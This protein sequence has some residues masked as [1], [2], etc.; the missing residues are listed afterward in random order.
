MANKINISK[1]LLFSLYEKEKLTTY[2]IAKKF[3]CCQ[4]TIWKRLIEFNIKRRTPYELNSNVPSK[5]QLI[6][7]YLNK[8]LS[9]WKIEEKYGFRR[10]T[11]HRKLKEYGLGTRDLA[12]SHIIYPRKDFSG[13]LIEKA[14]LTGFRIGDLGVRKIYPNSKTI[15]VASGSTIKEQIELIENLFKKYGKVNIKATKN[16][17][18][19]IWIALNESFNFLLSKE[20]PNWI[21]KNKKTF[22]AFLA[23]F[24]DAEG[25]ISK[26]NRI[27]YYY[28]LG[29]Y[30]SELLFKIYRNLNRFGIECKEPKS[31]NRKGKMNSQ[32]YKYNSNY[33][34]LRIYNQTI[35]LNLLKELKPYVKHKNK[36]KDLNRAIIGIVN[37]NKPRI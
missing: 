33:W 8:R 9:T 6:E 11:I 10:G 32:G 7:Y 31:D 37:R 21:E 27:T 16:H 2:Q 3:N 15:S 30:D 13:N 34:S 22:F 24:S 19:N 20:I 35:L 18:I 28:S 29:N 23:G 36:V 14:Y 4:A 1:E 26:K 17:K 12:T 5:N 25:S